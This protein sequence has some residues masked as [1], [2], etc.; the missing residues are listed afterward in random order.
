MAMRL[1]CFSLMWL[2]AILLSGQHARATVLVHDQFLEDGL[3]ADNVPMPGP[4]PAWNPGSATGVNAVTVAG[5]EA[6][7]IQ[8]ESF[9]GEDIAN[10]FGDQS[11]TAATYA[12][13]DFRL[14]AGDNAAVA[15]DP[16]LA[17]EGAYFIALRGTSPSMTLRARTGILAP[18]AGGD[19][20]FAINADNSNLGAGSIWPTELDFDTHYRAVISF[21]ASNAQSQLWIDPVNE[22][23]TSI[24]HTGG[25][26]SIGTV[27]NRI[28]LRQHD[29][30]DGKQLIDNV[31]IATTFADALSGGASAGVAGD[32]NG[33]G[34]VD[35][36]DYVVWRGM[37]DQTGAGLAADG[38]GDMTVDQ[39]D[40]D[41]WAARFG[42][43]AGSGGGLATSVPEPA[44]R[45]L[46]VVGV[47]CCHAARRRGPRPSALVARSRIPQH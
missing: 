45:L 13:F 47:G 9:N 10:V 2:T 23:S 21:D 32:Y 36:A 1:S 38:N 27:I 17:S 15:T 28:V 25:G 37:L 35:A 20:R 44:T 12:R 16:D 42:N 29:D 4:G 41:Y 39:A 46:L 3:L 11:T 43:M 8:T 33:N 7:L 5:G 18:I 14:P 6:V 40:Y 34:V 30:Y 31:V 22:M 19:F 26:G 24:S